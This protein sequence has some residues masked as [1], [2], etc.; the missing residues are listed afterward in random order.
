M[1]Y[2]NDQIIVNEGG[3]DITISLTAG[4]YNSSTLATHIQSVLNSNAGTSNTYTV[5]YRESAHRFLIASNAAITIN[6]T[7]TGSRHK[8][9]GK[10]IGFNVNANDTGQTSYFSDYPALGIPEDLVEAVST[11]VRF[12]YE[13]I[14]ERRI[15]KTSEST[16]MGSSSFSYS[17]IPSV[18]LDMLAPYVM[19]RV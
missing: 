16:D 1:E 3:S 14:R 18:A 10:L 8:E 12:R 11:I 7:A 2:F 9:L 4:E 19:L 6:W 13:E 5:S 15:G 17:G